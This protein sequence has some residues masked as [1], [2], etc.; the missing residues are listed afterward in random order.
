MGAGQ[1]NHFSSVSK[2]ARPKAFEGLGRFV[3]APRLDSPSR[4]KAAT[5]V[6]AGS[7]WRCRSKISSDLRE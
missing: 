5:A 2:Q 7:A 3:T 4:Q 6:I 1:D